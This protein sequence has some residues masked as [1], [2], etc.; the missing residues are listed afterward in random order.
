MSQNPFSAQCEK[1]SEYFKILLTPSEYKILDHKLRKVSKNFLD[2]G[3]LMNTQELFKIIILNLDD[4]R[5]LADLIQ[6][7]RNDC[8][9]LFK[10]DK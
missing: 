8:Q 5:L 6:L 3:L 9:S 10:V 1:K 2:N 7:Y 4:P